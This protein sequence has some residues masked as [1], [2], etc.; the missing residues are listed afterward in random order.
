MQ[1]EL[2]ILNNVWDLFCVRPEEMG[3]HAVQ[4]GEDPLKADLYFERHLDVCSHWCSWRT[5]VMCFFPLLSLW[6]P[7]L[8]TSYKQN[9][10]LTRVSVKDCVIGW[11]LV[12]VFVQKSGW[13]LQISFCFNGSAEAVR[14]HS[15]L[16]NCSSTTLSDNQIELGSTHIFHRK[17]TE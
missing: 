13:I 8:Y 6:E 4:C 2:I 16:Y 17:E 12:G 1:G 5:K 3:L 9:G 15:H 10:F 11:N 14:K 7:V